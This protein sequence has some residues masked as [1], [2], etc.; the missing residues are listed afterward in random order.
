MATRAELLQRVGLMDN[1]AHIGAL[2]HDDGEWAVLVGYGRSPNR[3]VA[4]AGAVQLVSDLRKID[5]HNLADCFEAAADMARRYSLRAGTHEDVT[6][7]HKHTVVGRAKP[8][9]K[10]L[11]R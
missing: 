2:Q 11:R 4:L 7:R 5:E 1:P 8:Q 9:P 10:A 3:M 6:S